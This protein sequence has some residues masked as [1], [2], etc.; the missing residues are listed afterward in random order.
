MS[1]SATANPTFIGHRGAGADGSF[2]HRRQRVL[3]NS[4]DS[5]ALA[6]SDGL[7][8]VELD[9]Q[10][11]RDGTPVVFHDWTVRLEVVGGGDDDDV[12]LRVPVG[13]LTA[14]QLRRIDV[15]PARCARGAVRRAAAAI[16]EDA[17][18][19]AADA[20]AAGRAAPR[21]AR[22]DAAAAACAGH[23]RAAAVAAAARRC[24]A[25]GVD[26]DA[27]TLARAAGATSGH[28]LR[29]DRG[30][31]VP[32][33]AAV[34]ARLGAGV[35]VNVELKYPAAADVAAFGLRVPPP[36]AF[37][38]AVVRVVGAAAARPI[39]YSS[40]SPAVAE[41]A[42]RAAPPAIDVLFLTSASAAE[43]DS[44]MASLAAAIDFAAAAGLQGVV[45]AAPAVLADARGAVAA[46]RARGLRLATY[47]SDNNVRERVRAQAAAGVDVI[48]LDDAA[49]ARD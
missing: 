32:S 9:V 2:P 49:A 30:G 48:I 41:A 6:A 33:L 34:L 45:A 7:R 35:G 28:G 38:A 18:A 44:R 23:G 4:H 47:G 37:V 21:D 24:A 5:F 3:E 42:R 15:Q 17:W 10:L 27:R 16:D 12:P 40:F 14:D 46:A 19:A 20:R 1:S 8:F 43:P 13:H 31:G 25:L 26:V 22:D 36:D 11:S 39:F 29:G